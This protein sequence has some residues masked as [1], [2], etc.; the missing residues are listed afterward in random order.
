MSIEMRAVF[1]H[2]V[3]RSCLSKVWLTER[4]LVKLFNVFA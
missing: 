4:E 1:I 3:M 2:Y